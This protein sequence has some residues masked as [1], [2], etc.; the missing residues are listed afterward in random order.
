MSCRPTTRVFCSAASDENPL[1]GKAVP[2][3]L[4]KQFLETA[5]LL[6]AIS[7]LPANPTGAGSCGPASKQL[8]DG[9]LRLSYQIP[10]DDVKIAVIAG[11]ADQ[12]IAA[13]A[14]ELVGGVVIA[15][16]PMQRFDEIAKQ[17]AG[18]N[19]FSAI[20]QDVRV[21]TKAMQGVGIMCESCG[22]PPGPTGPKWIVVLRPE[23]QTGHQ[24]QVCPI[25]VMAADRC[26]DR[27]SDSRA[28]GGDDR[29]GPGWRR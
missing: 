17:Y 10:Y 12:I 2:P 28:G 29:S 21:L 11:G 4:R 13:E 9:L 16:D 19:C 7:L 5:A 25:G 23:G 6:V 15:I 8:A 24:M 26:A 1:A 3:V 20:V 22:F 14:I 27:W 18:A